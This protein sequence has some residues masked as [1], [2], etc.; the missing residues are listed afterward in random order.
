MGYSH[1]MA[2][3]S[4]STA[5]DDAKRWHELESQNP[6]AKKLIR[7]CEHYLE[8]EKNFERDMAERAEIIQREST[9][10]LTD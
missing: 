6:N 7:D 5:Y 9:S 10:S 3:S 1:I 2:D 4:A 8:K